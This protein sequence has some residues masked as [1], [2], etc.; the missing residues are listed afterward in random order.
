MRRLLA[1]I[2]FAGGAGAVHAGEIEHGEFYPL[3]HSE[4]ETMEAAVRQVSKVPSS[5]QF[6]GV[7][8]T[9]T[10]KDLLNVC[11]FVIGAEAG[12][13]PFIG[14]MEPGG[15]FMLVLLGKDEATRVT[16]IDLCKRGGIDL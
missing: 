3:S 1:G 8:A 6:S 16:V 7:Q 5:A 12:S 13:I 11:G 2:I 4:V 15:R 14:V 9:R 10:D